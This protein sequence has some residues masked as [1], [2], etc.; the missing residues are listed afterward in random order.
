MSCKLSVIIVNYNTKELLKDCI[1]SL[2]SEEKLTRSSESKLEIIV[3]YNGSSD[4]S[5]EYLK[6]L[7]VTGYEL[8]VINNDKNL[9]FA[10][11]NNQ[12]IK[13]AQGEYIMLLNSDTIVK[14]GALK[15][16][17]DYLDN[18]PN[19]AGVS[20]QLLNKD[21]SK[22]IDYYM[23][24]PNLWQIVFYHNYP[25]RLV[26][27]NTPI[28][29]LFTKANK[30]KPFEVDQLPGAALATR[31]EIFDKY[32]DLDDSFNFFFEDVDW[33]FRIKNN[34]QQKLRVIPQA[35]ITHYG[36]ASWKKWLKKNRLGFYSQYYLSLLKFIEKNYKTPLIFYQLGLTFS[37][38]INVFFHFLLLSFQKV[39]VQLKLIAT[40]WSRDFDFQ[41]PE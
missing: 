27:M 13:I 19:V 17:V 3:V 2:F 29:Y 35:E 14:K 38:L 37:F 40:I 21:G 34:R 22:Q 20:P 25:L 33:C 26:A 23:K 41:L 28:K 31:R 15:T 32:G 11:A 5:K 30:N 36:G 39:K 1:Q 8:R 9:G 18:H 4:G 16:L 10:K 12:G 7:G 24:F 6:E